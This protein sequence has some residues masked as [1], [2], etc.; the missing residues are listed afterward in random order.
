MFIIT[1]ATMKPRVEDLPSGRGYGRQRGDAP[2][3]PMEKSGRVADR[4][5][6]ITEHRAAILT[7]LN[8]GD[9]PYTRTQVTEMLHWT[10][11][12]VNSNMDASDAKTETKPVILQ[13]IPVSH[14]APKFAN[15]PNVSA[16]TK[17]KIPQ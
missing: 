3:S 7:L 15:W 14:L 11:A 16:S 12:R 2:Y 8:E 6:R 9:F 4:E 17:A 10:A 1:R 5:E 13:P